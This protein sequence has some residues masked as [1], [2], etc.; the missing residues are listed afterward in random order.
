MSNNYLH[1]IQL[2][3][4]VMGNGWLL[5]PTMK[6]TKEYGIICMD[7]HMYICITCW[8]GSWY[9]YDCWGLIINIQNAQYHTQN[10]VWP[11]TKKWMTLT[12]MSCLFRCRCTK[13]LIQYSMSVLYKFIVLHKSSNDFSE[14]QQQR[15]VWVHQPQCW[16]GLCLSDVLFKLYLWILCITHTRLECSNLEMQFSLYGLLDQQIAKNWGKPNNKK[17]KKMP[18]LI[19][20]KILGKATI[21]WNSRNWVMDFLVFARILFSAYIYLKMPAYDIIYFHL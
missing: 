2:F 3:L 21:N 6:A 8:S 19:N 16:T 10:C 4:N 12:L 11:D 5:S 13:S 17:K 20:C 15:N 1:S 14:C 18:Y 9:E 7:I